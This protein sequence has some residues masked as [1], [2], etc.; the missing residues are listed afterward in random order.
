MEVFEVSRAVGGVLFTI[1][2]RTFG[3]CVRR[4]NAEVATLVFVKQATE[5]GR[6]VKIGPSVLQSVRTT[7]GLESSISTYQHIKSTLP[8]MPT[9]AQVLIFPIKP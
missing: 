8:S 4:A 6:R 9:R 5:Y 7:V 1:P 2:R 3:H